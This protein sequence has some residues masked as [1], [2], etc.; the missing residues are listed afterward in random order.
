MGFFLHQIHRIRLFDSEIVLHLYD[1]INKL[2]DLLFRSFIQL[3][4]NQKKNVF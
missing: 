4:A 3:K 2:E 1:V